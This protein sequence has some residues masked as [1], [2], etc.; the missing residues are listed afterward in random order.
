MNKNFA[1]FFLNK[2]FLAPKF[3]KEVN[4]CNAESTILANFGIPDIKKYEI[5]VSSIEEQEKIGKLLD[6][7]NNLITFNQWIVGLF[8]FQEILH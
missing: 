4:V 7:V 3:K 6:N 5:S 2:T 1:L 8:N